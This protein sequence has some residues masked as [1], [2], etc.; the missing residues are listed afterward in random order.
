MIILH[1]FII[2]LNHNHLHNLHFISLNLNRLS[3]IPN[4]LSVPY[5]I[6]TYLLRNLTSLDFNQINFTSLNLI[7]LQNLLNIQDFKVLI[8][9]INLIFRLIYP[10]IFK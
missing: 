8:H 2:I 7:N 5:L 1:P 3:L 6:P 4:L 10:F 9:L